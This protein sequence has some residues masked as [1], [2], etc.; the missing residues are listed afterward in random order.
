MPTPAA[1]TQSSNRATCIACRVEFDSTSA[2][3]DHAH[4]IR[5]QTSNGRDVTYTTIGRLAA[6]LS[7]SPGR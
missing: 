1:P 3:V 4:G 5:A 2:Q 7:P 6:E